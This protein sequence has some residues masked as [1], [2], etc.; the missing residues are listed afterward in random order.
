M[1]A[2]PPGQTDTPFLLCH[3]P[4]PWLRVLL[5]G[6]RPYH[7][8]PHVVCDSAA[9][10]TALAAQPLCEAVLLAIPS[11][12]AAAFAMLQS[13]REAG[14]TVPVLVL[15]ESRSTRLLAATMEAGADEFL[16]HTVLAV[17][18][19]ARLRA[20]LRRHRL[21]SR[22]APLVR[23]A[24]DLCCDFHEQRVSW[25]GQPVP[26]PPVCRKILF[27]LMERPGQM[28][29]REV[30]MQFIWNRRSPSRTSNAMPVAI[31]RLRTALKAAGVPVRIATHHSS[32]YSLQRAEAAAS[33]EA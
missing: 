32:G 24:F 28:V 27:L 5:L 22:A 9:E 7:R 29:A 4:P 6:L 12:K 2:I 15:S 26:M 3:D 13:L 25:Q 18:L 16:P 14:C 17:E 23:T 1:S 21:A 20:R 19:A 11:R 30:L 33:Q 31:N 10:L 8:V